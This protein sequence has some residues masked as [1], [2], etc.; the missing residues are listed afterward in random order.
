[1]KR[2]ATSYRKTVEQSGDLCFKETMMKGVGET[3]QCSQL[4]SQAFPC[5]LNIFA[6]FIILRFQRRIRMGFYTSTFNKQENKLMGY[7]FTTN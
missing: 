1:M 7:L 4:C 5:S 6:G 2:K 3:N